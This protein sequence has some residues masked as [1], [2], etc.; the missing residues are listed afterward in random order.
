[1]NLHGI[2]SA[3]IGSVNPQKAMS[4]LISTGYTTAADGTQQPAYSPM[5]ASGQV[6]ELSGKDLMRLNG[7]NVQGVTQKAYLTGD[8]EGVFRVMGKGGDLIKFGGQTY[9]VSAVLERWPDW[10]CV[11]LTVQMDGK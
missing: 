8:F 2:V 6:Q 9:L 3:A 5:Q 1:M 4:V 10:V 7:L 11:A